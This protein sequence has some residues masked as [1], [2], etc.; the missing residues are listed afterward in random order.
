[1]NECNLLGFPART[2]HVGLVPADVKPLAREEIE[3]QFKIWEQTVYLVTQSLELFR[4]HFAG[5]ELF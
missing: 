3:I 1:L 5:V 4:W 2:I